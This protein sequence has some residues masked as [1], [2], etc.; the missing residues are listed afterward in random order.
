MYQIY[1]NLKDYFGERM[2]ICYS[3]TNAFILH[4]KSDDLFVELHC[5]PQIR[6]L[7]DIPLITDNQTTGVGDPKDPC[8]GVVCFFKD[9]CNGNVL[10][11]LIT[12]KRKM[13]L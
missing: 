7:I 4:I 5:Q 11:K 1:A 13:Y 6:D 9:D 2:C 8:A 3:D 10:T 12:L